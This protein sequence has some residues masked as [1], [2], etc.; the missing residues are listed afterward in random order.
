MAASAESPTLTVMVVAALRAAPGKVAVT[1]VAVASSDSSTLASDTFS[2]MAPSSS[3]MVSVWSSGSAAPR[4]PLAVPDT[5][6][7]LSAAS[8]SLSTAVMV[9]V[10]VLAVA[11]AAIVS[12]L[13]ADTV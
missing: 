6:T 8:A 4:P 3:A 7:C 1:V 11:P 10:P 2:A 13:F 5:V 9:T 12:V